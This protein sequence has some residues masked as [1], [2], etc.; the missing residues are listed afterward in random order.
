MSTRL[1]H[2]CH[3][4]RSLVTET[5]L[6]RVLQRATDIA[7]EVLEARYAAI[8]VLRADG[9]TFGTFVTSGIDEATRQAIGPIPS[10]AGLLGLVVREARVIRLAD[11]TSHPDASG[12]PSG[13][14]PM[15]SFLGVPVR[16]Q[17]V[18]FGNLYVTEKLTGPEFTAEDEQMAQ[19]LATST[20]AAIRN[21]RLHE[22]THQ[23]LDEVQ[24]LMRGRERFFAMINHELRNSLT[25][26]QG[27]SEMALRTPPA[28][29]PREALTEVL[30]A[31]QE[32]MTL[33]ADLLDLARLEEDRLRITTN[34]VDPA[35]LIRRAISRIRPLALAADVELAVRHDELIP[36]IVTD[37]GR[38]EQIL[39]NLLTNAI[40]H[41]PPGSTVEVCAA[42]QDSQ[43]VVT[44]LDQGPGVAAT[45][46]DRIFNVY[47]SRR[48]AGPGVGLGLA[49]S[50][51]LA[52]LL[53]GSLIA[54]HQAAGGGR[55]E[56]RLPGP[57]AR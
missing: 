46:V 1:L 25:A 14:P 10:G 7:C 5:S 37:A 23:L 20:A 53:G 22:E 44:V 6:E 12:F 24:R 35:E 29:E 30:E 18:V 39:N 43:V 41:A 50:R 52:A 42:A 49:V 45:D 21:A 33:V 36:P 11:L 19:L 13:H 51:R 34:A 38:V 28:V 40:R 15:R 17:D 32:A 56:L 54:I 27:W 26:V 2:L 48:G 55:F 4:S 31:S 8:G 9:R 47:E 16:S 3:V 57:E